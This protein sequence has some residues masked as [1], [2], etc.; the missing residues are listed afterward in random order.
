MSWQTAFTLINMLV[1]PAWAMLILIPGARIT[2][3]LVH[4][5]LWP[6]VMGAIYTVSLVAAMGFGV[7][8]PEAGFTLSGV[9]A[10]FQHPNGVITG[11]THFLVFDLFVGAWIGRDSQRLSV[12]HWQTLPCILFAF[13][14]GPVGLLLYALLRLAHGK[15]FSLHET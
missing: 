12:P 7:S 15:G 14:F 8:D 9:T 10:L 5:M 2:K 4:S 6:L 1:L 11:W 3:T 13:L